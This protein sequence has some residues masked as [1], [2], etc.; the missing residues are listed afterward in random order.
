MVTYRQWMVDVNNIVE[1]R[2][3]L[4]LNLLPDWLSRDSYEDGLT[5][6]EGAD[7]CLEQ[8][9]FLEYEGRVLDEA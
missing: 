4:P 8:T 5:P 1:K 9:G 7:V 6:Q 3:G 2:T